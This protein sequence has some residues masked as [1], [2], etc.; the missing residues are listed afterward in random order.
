MNI[1]LAVI[2]AGLAAFSR[3]SAASPETPPPPV[4]PQP[5][6]DIETLIRELA[7]ESYRVREN[8]T[9]DLWKLGDKALPA[10]REAIVSP[11]PEQVFRAREVLRKI[12][13]HITPDTDPGII[14]L[15]ERYIKASPTEKTTLL[16]K[17]IAKRAWRQMLKLYASETNAEV[18]EKLLPAVSGIALKAARERLAQGDPAEAR[19]FLEM[20]PADA[21]GLLALAEFHRSHGTLAAELERARGITGRKSQAW[22]LALQRASGNLAAATAAAIAAEEPRI[23]ASMAALAGDPLPWLREVPREEPEEDSVGA[24]YAAIAAKRWQGQKIRPSDLEPL[25]KALAT[26]NPSERGAGIKALFLLGELDAAEASFAKSSPLAAFRHFE[27]LERIPQALKALSLDPDRPDYKSW[28]K[29]RLEKVSADEIQEQPGVSEHDDEQLVALANFLERRGLH[30][31]AMASFADLMAALAVK[32]VNAFTDF[33]GALFGGRET[34]SGAPRLAMRIAKAWADDDAKRWDEVVVAAFGDEDSPKVWWSWLAELEPKSSR[35]ERFDGMLALFGLGSDP[36][37]L[38]E[39]W[40]AL[41]WKQV[42]QAPAKDRNRLVEHISSLCT[43]TGDVANCLK[44]WDLLPEASR[45]EVFWGIH[46]LHLSAAERWNEAA[47]IFLKQ[48]ALATDSNQEPPAHLHAYAASALRQAGRAEDAISH[49]KWADKLAL[50]NATAAI[51]IGN[52][53][54]YGR[55]YKRAAEWWA[56]AAREADPDSGEFSIAFKLHADVL[57]EYGKWREAAATSEVLSRICLSSDFRSSSLLLLMR[58]RLQSDTARALSI[59]PTD[60]VGAISILG[61]CHR[62]FASDG[63]L[64]DFFFPSL[65]R[66]GLIKEHDEWFRISWDLMENIIESHPGSENTR[67]TAAWF[68]SRAVRK[69]DEAEKLLA[70]ALAANPGQPAY[71]DTMAEIQFARGNREK[72]LEW[73]QLAVNYLPSDSQ[74]RRQQERFRSEPLPK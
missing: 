55:D 59:L 30:E 4:A 6:K 42:S 60:R 74:L 14:A 63:S 27:A 39:K 33:L 48:I 16:S 25:A 71:L 18:R 62:A 70:K 20:A 21:D 35:I 10:L 19:E 50:G 8:A 5:A 46:V 49:D 54:A 40:L 58:E 13:L 61:K 7:D 34:L 68:A 53:Y 11:D 52:G 38:R 66:V 69:L 45:K 15:V 47:E 43:E 57:L 32:D 22:Q 44:A 67:N 3:L 9:R 12:Q 73:S 64:A 2:L 26:R 56:R 17:M 72:A 65:R 23:A 51:Q 29:K 1:P 37:K 36:S 24:V 28:V 41:A 31:E